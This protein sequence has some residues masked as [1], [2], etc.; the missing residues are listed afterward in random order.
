[1][2]GGSLV[3]ENGIECNEMEFVED[4]LIFDDLSFSRAG[5][6]FAGWYT[7]EA[8]ADLFSINGV[9]AKMPSHSITLYAKWN[10]L[11]YNLIFDA[12][13]GNLNTDRK[14]VLSDVAVGELPVPEK[15]YYTFDGWFTENGDKVTAETAFARTDDLKLVAHWT[16]N[17]F[18][19][20]FNANCDGIAN[21][22]MRAYCGKALGE[23]PTPQRDYY[24]FVGWYTDVT[25][26]VKV[27]PE[28]IYYVAEDITL[29]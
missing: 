1:M 7:D 5:Y 20:S 12:N 17:S 4:S 8:F 11:T 2:N 25:G 26:G 6:E 16:L 24:D 28:S 13:G 19:V 9:D 23:L 29:Y 3:D 27:T 15:Q 22:E 21:S 18:I 10:A 14:A